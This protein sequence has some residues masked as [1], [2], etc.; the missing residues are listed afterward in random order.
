[1]LAKAMTRSA[2]VNLHAKIP[3]TARLLAKNSFGWLAG[4]LEE[5]G[6]AHGDGRFAKLMAS[7]AKTDLLILDWGLAPFT[8]E[9]RRDMLELLDDRYG[10]RSPLVT[11][12][13]PVDK[14]HELIGDPTLAD[15][16]LDRLVH[17]AYRVELKI[18]GGG[19][20]D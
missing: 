19:S 5:L 2:G 17:N 7:Y 3:R 10:Q 6:M 1:M 9:Q 12:Q 13:M 15:A 18:D 14:W 4:W 8:A 11:S 16:I 20:S